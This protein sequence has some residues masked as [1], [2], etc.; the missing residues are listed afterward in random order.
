[1]SPSSQNIQPRTSRREVQQDSG[2]IPTRL[3]VEGDLTDYQA[4]A[5]ALEAVALA[6]ENAP[7]MT[8]GLSRQIRPLWGH[9]FYGMIWD[10]PVVWYQE[11]G[12][13]PFTMR[14]LAGRLIP[15][16]IK[17][18]TGIE[19]HKSPKAKTRLG[20]DG[21]VRVLIFRRAAKMGARKNVIRNGVSVNVPQSFPGA[22]G[23]I[24]VREAAAPM[25]RPGKVRGQIAGR[26]GLA[27][28]NVGVRWRH[29][30]LFGR[31]FMH[32]AMVQAGVNIGFDPNTPVW[33]TTDRW[34]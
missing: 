16:W 22:P 30:G 27:R 13:R 32:H 33:A 10:D 3:Y 9:G 23:R 5:V 15:M 18:P 11:I 34:K 12:T 4:H 21:V 6:R 29:P 24:S 8:G 2:R 7:K 1:V 28:P 14:S 31:N 19:R 17:D 25:T 26:S 20:E